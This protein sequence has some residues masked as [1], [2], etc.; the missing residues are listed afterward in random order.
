MRYRPALACSFSPL[1]WFSIQAS[2]SLGRDLGQVDRR[3]ERPRSGRRTAAARGRGALQYSSRRRVVLVTPDVAAPRASPRPAARTSLMNSFSSTRSWVHSVS[4]IEL[5]ALL[6]GLGD[7]DEVGAE[8]PRLDDLV[9]DAVVVEL[10]VARRLLEGRVDDRV[11][12]DDLPHAALRNSPQRARLALSVAYRTGVR[13]G[14]AKR[15]GELQQVHSI[16][17]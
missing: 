12:D 1:S 2:P 14:R 7:G 3:L 13:D 4:K 10:E 11:L 5:L 16:G 15:P 8:A 9:G 6:L 17:T